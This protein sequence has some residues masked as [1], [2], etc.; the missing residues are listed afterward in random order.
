VFT[1]NHPK[2]KNLTNSDPT[3]KKSNKTT[4]NTRRTNDPEKGRQKKKEAKT[5]RP[6]PTPDAQM[7][8]L[9]NR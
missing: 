6:T 5:K 2:K 9:K 4:P 7:F 1:Q 3:I 8:P